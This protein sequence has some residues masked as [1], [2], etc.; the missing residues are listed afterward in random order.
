MYA[1]LYDGEGNKYIVPAQYC[2]LVEVAGRSLP[3]KEEHNSFPVDFDLFELDA[4][5]DKARSEKIGGPQD[6]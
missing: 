3:D 1:Y 6:G 5:R 4:L 2:V